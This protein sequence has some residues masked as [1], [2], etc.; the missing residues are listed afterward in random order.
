[1]RER[2]DS[3]T[4]WACSLCSGPGPPR[5]VYGPPE[6][7][8]LGQE[9]QGKNL[10][11]SLIPQGNQWAECGAHGRVRI[12]SG[13]GDAQGAPR[14]GELPTVVCLQDGAGPCRQQHFVW[15][16]LPCFWLF[17]FHRLTKYGQMSLTVH[18]VNDCLLLGRQ[19]EQREVGKQTDGED[20]F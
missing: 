12:F 17:R 10:G 13:Y 20:R 1:M 3:P 11:S 2:G 16:K 14:E 5:G 18:L 6:G 8:F 19:C 7:C 9:S 4:P 15:L